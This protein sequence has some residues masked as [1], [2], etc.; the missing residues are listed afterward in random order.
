MQ[1]EDTNLLLLQTWAS[2]LIADFI[3]RLITLGHANLHLFK[4]LPCPLTPALPEVIL[5]TRQPD[6][7]QALLDSVVAEQFELSHAEFAYILTKLPLLDRDQ[8]PLPHDYRLR[9][10]NKGLDRRMQSFI[11]RDLT[12]LTTSTT[13]PAVW[14]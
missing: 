1:M 14:K 11:T 7:R 5:S 9:A 12:L 3:T 10:T 6:S 4:Q 13:W 2:S 8:P